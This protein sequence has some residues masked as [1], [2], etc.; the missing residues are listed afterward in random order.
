M[1]AGSTGHLILA[2]GARPTPDAH[3]AQDLVD[4]LAAASKAVGGAA[5]PGYDTYQE[6]EEAAKAAFGDECPNKDEETDHNDLDKAGSDKDKNPVL[7]PLHALDGIPT[8]T[9]GPAKSKD[10]AREVEEIA[11]KNP[12]TENFTAQD[13]LVVAN[14]TGSWA[15]DLNRYLRGG[16]VPGSFKNPEAKVKMMDEALSHLPPVPDLTVYRGTFMPE[17]VLEGLIDGN[18]VGFPEYLSTSTD[19]GKAETALDRAN[20]GGIKGEKVLLEIETSNGRNVDPLSRY[21]GKE[22]EVLIPRDGKF[23]MTSQETRVINGKEVKVIK[24]TQTG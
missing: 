23:T 2:T 19:L 9:P 3:A 15:A 7:D 11:K 8:Y 22:S 24:V 10:W 13:A 4:K 1:Y 12:L 21:R 18:E 14:Y 20:G 6:A 16:K 17:S 5:V